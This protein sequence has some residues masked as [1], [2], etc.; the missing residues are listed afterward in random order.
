MMNFPDGWQWTTNDGVRNTVFSTRQ[1]K[2]SFSSHGRFYEGHCQYYNWIARMNYGVS[3][4]YYSGHGTGGSGV[5]FMWN[6]VEEQFPIV[7]TTHEWLHNFN[8]W[9]GWRGYMWDDTQTKDPRW[10]G[11]TWFNPKEPNLYC[12]VHYKWLDQNFQ[13]LH[14]EIDLW[15][16]CTTAQNMGP[17]IYL[18]HGSALWYGNAGTGLCPEEDLLDDMWVQDMMMNGSSIGQALSKYVW[19]HQRDFTAKQDDPAKYEA[20]L[21][22]SSSMQTTNVQCIYGDPT[23]TVCSP[24]WIEPVPIHP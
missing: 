12:I 1:V 17:Q 18:E 10:G 6:N 11:F 14:S 19:L 5:S 13:N 4:N 21:Y 15:M 20:S 22:G 24:E 8:W 3:V 7:E 16:S 23:L 2:E 9:D